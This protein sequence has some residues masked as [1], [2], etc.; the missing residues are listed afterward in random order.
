[1]TERRKKRKENDGV[2]I[3][4]SLLVNRVN[5]FIVCDSYFF[6]L[7]ILFLLRHGV[8]P[9]PC[10]RSMEIMMMMMMIWE[11]DTSVFVKRKTTMKLSSLS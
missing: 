1:M 7:F 8:Y 9:R 6:F 4:N 10:R 11:T 5:I 3:S 2:S